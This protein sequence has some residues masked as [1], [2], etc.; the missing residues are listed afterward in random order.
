MFVVT[1]S[2][3]FF[4]VAV[5]FSAVVVLAMWVTVTLMDRKRAKQMKREGRD[6]SKKEI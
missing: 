6:Q 3:V 5:I 1:P 4:G 2:D